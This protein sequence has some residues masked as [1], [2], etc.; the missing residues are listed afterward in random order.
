MLRT[1]IKLPDGTEISSGANH[2][3]AIQ[4][5][6]LTECVNSGEDLILGSACSNALEVTLFTPDGGLSLEAG[7]EVAV[8]KEDGAARKDVGVFILEKPTRPTAN[9]M[10]VTGYDR[11]SKLDK[12]LS[13][14][15]SGLKEWPYPLTTFAGMV[16]DACGLE[17]KPSAV[18]NGDFPVQQF[19]R[20]TVTGRQI[21][22][23]LG[24]ICARF[25]RATP[26]GKI[27]FAWYADSGKAITTGGEIYY[28]QNGL[29][30][31]DY[32]TAKVDAVQLRLANSNDGALWP[33]AVGAVNSYIIT[34]N[35]ILNLQITES[36]RPVLANIQAAIADV[37]YTP[38]KVSIPANMDIRA[39]NTVRITDKNGKN[40]TAYV[41]TKTQTG[42]KDTLECTGNRMRNTSAAVNN[43]TAAEKAAE[44]NSYAD[45]A[46]KNAAQSAVDK[47]TQEDIF[48]KLTNNGQIQGIY[49][50][51]GK[52]YIN[53]E[54]AQILNL[55]V[56][57]AQ[58]ESLEAGKITG[59]IDSEQI[60][61]KTLVI[62]DGAKICTWK[63]DHNSIYQDEGYWPH[64]TF[65]CTG[66]MNPY[67]IGGSPEIPNWVFGAGGK[68]G[69]TK[70]GAVYASDAYITGHIT[71]NDGKIGGWNIGD[72]IIESASGV[73]YSGP[74]IYSDAYYDAIYKTEISIALTSGKVYAWG[75]DSTGASFVDYTSWGAIMRAAN[76]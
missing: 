9:T 53:A 36:L 22:Q 60:N 3:N 67:S 40:I 2:K 55:I 71:A 21:M 58:I 72:V 18:I 73:V 7:A 35:A 1:I 65:M 12:D 59:L 42:Q 46:A 13:A 52:W 31:E 61:G 6:T 76:S 19:T 27:E 39:G 48:N 15:L 11:V 16:C 64:G 24:E 26:D 66:S 8:Y 54:L 51:D 37:S 5:A 29:S 50:K 33:E 28:F 32:E 23:W 14:W 34:G 10:K 20:S 43:K 47:Q 25:C 4:S 62:E 38:C 44:A 63:V 49:I 74:A 45:A 68:F 30:Y 41:M 75:R 17:Y 56:K 69:V 57:S 70:G